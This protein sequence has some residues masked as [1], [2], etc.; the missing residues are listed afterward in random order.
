MACRSQTPSDS[1]ADEDPRARTS[2]GVSETI[3]EI[4]RRRI[5]EFTKFF[6]G[7]VAVAALSAEQNLLVKRELLQSLSRRSVYWIALLLVASPFWFVVGAWTETS[8]IYPWFRVVW[9]VGLWGLAAP[10]AAYLLKKTTMLPKHAGVG[11]VEQMHWA[12]ASLAMLT[13]FW[14]AAASFGLKPPTY[15]TGLIVHGY[16]F[17]FARYGF[18]ELTMIGQAITLLVLAPSFR[19]ALG[20]LLVGTIPFAFDMAPGFIIH[21]PGMFD[22]YTAQLI[23]YCVIARYI[24]NDQQLICVKEVV[25]DEAR[26]Q[27]VATMLEKNQFIAAISHDL[28][29]PLTTLGLKLSFI[30]RCIK[31]TSL[32]DDVSM[33]QRQVDAM[34]GMINGALDIS[35]LESHTWNVEIQEVALPSLLHGIVVD[36]QPLAEAK[37][38]RLR[39]HSR[40]YLVRTDRHALDRIVRNMV[41]NAIRYTPSGQGGNN[42]HVLVSCQRRG[43]RVKINV[44]D[45]GIGIPEDRQADIFKSYVQV[46]NPERNRD[47]GFGLGLAIVQGLANLLGHKLDV[48]SAPG[49]GSRFSVMVPFIGLIPPELLEVQTVENDSPDLTNMV[50]AVI[51]DNSDLRIEISMRLIEHGCYV[52]AGKSSSD[53]IEQ[54]SIEALASGP[55]FILSDYRLENEDGVAAIAALRAVTNASIPAVLWSG[56]TSSA[57]L[58][59]V[60]ASGMKLL[61]KPVSEQTLLTLLAGHQPKTLTDDGRKRGQA[62]TKPAQRSEAAPDCQRPAIASCTR[63]PRYSGASETPRPRTSRLADE[64]AHSTGRRRF[65]D[66]VNLFV[67]PIAALSAEQNLYVKRELLQSLSR[68]ALCWTALVSVGASL[69]CVYGSWIKTS[70]SYLWFRVVW[71][72]GLWGVAT[73]MAAY[74]LKKTMALPKHAGVNAIEQMHWAWAAMV[75]LT[76]FWW[77]AGS[78]GLTPPD[79]ISP[80]ARYVKLASSGF[81]E[82]TLI[83]HTFTL[84]LLAPSLR[85]NLGSFVLGAIPFGFSLG[86][87]LFI[88][89]PLMLVFY[90]AQVIGYCLL[91]FFVFYNEKH[92][93]VKEIILDEAR[94]RAEAA[95]AEKSL[96][97][98]AISHDLRQPLTTLG[99]KL[100]FIE[101]SIESTRMVDDVSMAQRQVDTM[102]G[103]IN[104]ALDICR[105]ESGTWSVEIQEVALT[106]LLRGIV[107]DMQPLAEAKGLRLRLHS[108]PY[109]VRTDRHALDRIVRNMVINAVRYTPS[110]QGGKSGHVLVS[111]QRRG[112][113]VKISVWDN[114]IGIPE[115]RQADIFKSY[116]QVDNPERNREK[117]L[118]LGLSIVQGL[119]DLLGHKLDVDSAPGRGSRFSVTVPFMGLIPPELLEV[120]TVEEGEAD[121]T[122][123]VVAIIEDNSDLRIEISMRLIEHGCYVVAGESSSDV[124]EQLRIEELETGPHFILSDYRLENEDGIAAIAAVRAVTNASIPAVLWSG[125]TSSAV[126]KKVAAS[127]MKLLSKPVSEQTL[128]TL[129]AKHKPR[130]NRPKAGASIRAAT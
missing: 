67:G 2:V 101:R 108:R 74:L 47:K 65:A 24:C 111:C 130:E 75:T 95:K 33:A 51:E 66:F 18:M 21:R 107:A 10:S 30:E 125:D 48:D 104:G 81:L 105:L 98:A 26:A 97:I 8:D 93:Y 96:L 118:G 121:L 7:P 80:Q 110:G 6:V 38:L 92:A 43:S 102:E 53:V 17:R 37:G 39:L 123:M 79:F 57:V 83:S 35:R 52:V 14:W 50:V 3:Q 55:H 61:S 63:T 15:V 45:N 90:T 115:D 40:P 58:K 85:A 122:D 127:G 77:A 129:L 106:S 16:Y 60:A 27:A 23:G 68:R 116:V 114:G 31:S 119:A 32:V 89:R 71:P 64:K 73:P 103:M 25:L 70:D 44:W 72:L 9:I 56:D 109:L 99:L 88:Y 120:Q 128:L 113:R 20:A 76:S 86:P 41:I 13:S 59:K 91:A 78:F 36:M 34:E 28:R 11:E 4:V 5:A 46:A 87:P 49:R 124:I 19:A 54:L 22:W 69:L 117:G 100:S 29:Q 42:G 112:S 1:D 12:W 84:L 82:Y 126:L 62:N 94:E